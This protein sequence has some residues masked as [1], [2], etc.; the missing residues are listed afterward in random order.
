MKDDRSSTITSK[1][2]WDLGTKR[3]KGGKQLFVFRI[4]PC[5]IIRGGWAVFLPCT[6]RTGVVGFACARAPCFALAGLGLHWRLIQII[7]I[8]GGN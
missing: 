4:N 8:S 5:N 6:C 7:G 1:E 3:K 2:R